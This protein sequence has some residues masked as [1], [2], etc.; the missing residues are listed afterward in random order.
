MDNDYICNISSFEN[1][2]TCMGPLFLRWYIYIIL[3][4]NRNIKIATSKIIAARYGRNITDFVKCL[5]SY[6]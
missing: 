3:N 6:C 2:I 1:F 5:R 4:F